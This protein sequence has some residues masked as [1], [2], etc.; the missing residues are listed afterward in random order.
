MGAGKV[1]TLIS[2]IAAGSFDIWESGALLPHFCR[3][4]RHRRE[5]TVL[6]GA[7]RLCRDQPMQPALL[8]DDGTMIDESIAICR[9]FEGNGRK[10]EQ[11]VPRVDCCHR[12]AG[13][14]VILPRRN[15]GQ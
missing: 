6:F 11:T 2:I 4:R 1:E 7:R 8:L 14:W 5:I 10:L 12:I 3:S 9:Y 15:Y 13:G